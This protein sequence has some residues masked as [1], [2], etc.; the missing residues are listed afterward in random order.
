MEKQG[1]LFDRSFFVLTK[2]K[3]L[4]YRCEKLKSRPPDGIR[5]ILPSIHDAETADRRQGWSWTQ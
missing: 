5:K 4:D 1:V 3:A 2:E